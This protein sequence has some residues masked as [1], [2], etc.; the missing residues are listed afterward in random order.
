M[1]ALFVSLA[2]YFV[3]LPTQAQQQPIPDWTSTEVEKLCV[4]GRIDDAISFPSIRA[5]ALDVRRTLCVQ[6][7][8]RSDVQDAFVRF[9]T[10]LAGSDWFKKF[11]GFVDGRDPF[12]AVRDLI[13]LEKPTY[14]T[15]TMSLADLPEIVQSET[16]KPFA[17]ADVEACD[18]LAGKGKDGS[19][20]TCRDVL[21]EVRSLFE[22]ARSTLTAGRALEFT[23]QVASLGK[24][25]DDFLFHSRS[26]TILELAANSA[27]YRANEPL[28]FGLP[29]N[30]QLIIL[31]PNVV[32]ENV[33]GAIDGDKT[34]DA[35]MVEVFGLNW[36]NQMRWYLPTG[37][38]AIALYAD[39]ADVDDVGYGLAVH[40]RSVYTLGYA[41][42]GG[43][44]GF[45]IS[46]DLLKLVQDKKGILD[47]YHR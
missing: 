41:D 46:M 31:H 40:F 15:L 11:G 14:P 2:L 10:G 32:I 19:E 18:K 45:F 33:S 21:D 43:D 6:K 44:D 23:E 17:P 5:G 1:R 16:A 35:R 26:Q 4:A 24:Q 29:P 37:V 9:V 8:T 42:H 7:G 28:Q 30:R 27:I 38:S 13:D 36:W 34:M 20:R 3:V 22:Y 25:W 39:R 12:E 47:K